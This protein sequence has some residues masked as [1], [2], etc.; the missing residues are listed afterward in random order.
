LTLKK[1]RGEVKAGFRSAK[2]VA[3]PL[4]RGAGGLRCVMP[5]RRLLI[6]ADIYGLT[7]ELRALAFRLDPEAV[8]LSPHADGRTCA[9]EA[10][11]YAAFQA[12]G[13]VDAYAGRLRAAL[14]QTRP[15][16]ALGFSAGASALWLCLPEID[17]GFPERALLYY[18][19]RIRESAHLRPACTVRLVFA[20][21][22][23]SF[24][25][26]PLA[27]RLAEAGLDAAVLP[28]TA[29]GFMNPRSPGYDATICAR[30]HD[31]LRDFFFPHQ[32]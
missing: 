12:A 20:E 30:E 2:R 13:G 9:D 1:T 3:N 26:H 19:S 7:P 14:A 18:G 27:R 21:R 23:A 28:G 11:A 31:R 29:H 25:P 24:D 32:K 15:Q 8:L 6:A 4:P 5:R 10:G 17:P 16:C 22:E